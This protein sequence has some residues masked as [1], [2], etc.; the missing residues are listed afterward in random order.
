[1][2]YKLKIKFLLCI[3][4]LAVKTVNGQSLLVPGDGLQ[5]SFSTGNAQ[6]KDNLINGLRNNGLSFSLS[7]DYSINKNL[8]NHEIGLNVDFATLWNRYGW[9][10]WCLQPDIHY[11]LL[12]TVN[13]HLQLGGNVSYSSLYYQNDYFDSH[14][15]YWCTNF[16]LGFSVCYQTPVNSKWTLYIP[17][18][19]P[20]IGF[21][22]RPAANRNLILYEPDL[23]FYDVLKRMNSNFQFVAIG[24]KYF[25]IETGLFFGIRLHSNRQI[26]IGYKVHYEQT[27]VSLKSQMLTNQICVQ[28][29]FSKK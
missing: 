21:L 14:H 7:A 27:D 15:N 16:N 11:R 20:L 17:I 29:S 9:N 10:S 25:E 8:L 28:Y 3:L 2:R 12:T 4:L 13:K 1:M 24:Y 26:N 6:Y 23:K 19:L 22:S 18:N 5:I